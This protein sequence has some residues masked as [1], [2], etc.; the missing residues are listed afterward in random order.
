MPNT[1]AA[2]VG[3]A[4]PVSAV[5]P[6][7][8]FDETKL[9]GF[10]QA[11]IPDFGDRMSV[12]QFQERSRLEPHLPAERRRRP[13]RYVLRK[14]PP[15]Q[16]LA[17]AHQVDREFRIMQ[18]LEGRVPVPHMRALCRDASVIGADFYVMDFLDGPDLPRRHAARPRSG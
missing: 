5:A 8:R 18:A 16:L 1:D 6:A 7:H 2:P 17:S 14:K 13:T 11:E 15:G 9:L 12:R 4:L 3:D 10:L